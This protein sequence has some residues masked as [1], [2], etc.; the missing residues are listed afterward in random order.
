MGRRGK[1]TLRALRHISWYW[2]SLMGDNHYQRYV[3]HRARRH[4]GEAVMSEREYWRHR[5]AA[6]DAD[7][8]ARCC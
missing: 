5:H 3:E 7:P 2:Q 1:G 4:A 8:G 6:A